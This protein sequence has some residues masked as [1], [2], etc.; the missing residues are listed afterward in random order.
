MTMQVLM[1]TGD[2]SHIAG[3]VE[4]GQILITVPSFGVA[5]GLCQSQREQLLLDKALEINPDLSLTRASSTF[6]QPQPTKKAE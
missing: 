1:L 6:W 2:D 4:I 5:A 3:Q